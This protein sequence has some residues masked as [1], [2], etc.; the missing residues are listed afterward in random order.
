MKE[1]LKLSLLGKRV[2]ALFG[3][4]TAGNHSKGGGRVLGVY[5]SKDVP[6]LSPGSLGQLSEFQGRKHTQRKRI[7]LNIAAQYGMVAI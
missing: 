2:R 7:S 3:F 5:K 4:T 6:P 1:A